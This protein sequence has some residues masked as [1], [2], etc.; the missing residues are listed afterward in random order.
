MDSP[1]TVIA[2]PL[3]KPELLT[4]MQAC[5]QVGVSRRTIYHWIKSGKLS[6][7]KTA[8]GR[9]RIHAHTLWRKS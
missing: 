7:V 8:G 6:T 1:E 2:A 4:I 5:Q 3:D 9:T